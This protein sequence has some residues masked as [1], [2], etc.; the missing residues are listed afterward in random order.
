MSRRSAIRRVSISSIFTMSIS[1]LCPMSP[2]ISKFVPCRSLS[3]IC[4]SIGSII[5]RCST[6]RLDRST[7]GLSSARQVN[8]S[9]SLSRWPSR[10]LDLST[11]SLYTYFLGN[12][13]TL[14]HRSVIFGLRELNSCSI[15]DERTDFSSNYELRLFTSACYYLDDQ[16]RWQSDGLT[17]GPAS[18]HYETQCF[19]RHLTRFASGFAIL[20]EPVNWKKVFANGDFLKNKTIYLTVIV[21]ALIYLLLLIYARFFDGMDLKKVERDRRSF[22]ERSLLLIL[23]GSDSVARQ[24]SRRSLFLSDSRLHR[25]SPRFRNEIQSASLARLS[26]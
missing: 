14:N 6:L 26:V 4:S 11:E 25:S 8:Q 16:N 19:S 15:S 23:V 1:L 13:Q 7:A 9:I 3:P 10:C 12:D 24:S 5:P 18:N 22:I 2:F 17:V 21:V 20:P